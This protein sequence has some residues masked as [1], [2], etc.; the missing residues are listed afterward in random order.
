MILELSDTAIWEVDPPLIEV[1]SDVCVSALDTCEEVC[2]LLVIEADGE[3]ERV[4][5]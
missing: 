5:C 3:V 2:S 4:E 1:E